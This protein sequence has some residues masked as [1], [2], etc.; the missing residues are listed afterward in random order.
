[1]GCDIHGMFEYMYKH[2][3]DD[4]DGR[5]TNAGDPYKWHR[6]Y[7]IY[8]ILGNVRNGHKIP[9]I[10][11]NRLIEYADYSQDDW[12]NMGY[13]D[14]CKAPCEEFQHLSANWKGDGHSHSFVTLAEMKAYDINQ[15][16]YDNR[17]ICGKDDDGNITSTCA[18]TT[19]EHFGPVGEI[20]IF[21]VWGSASWQ[22]LI[23]Y[24]EMIREFYGLKDD[25]VRYTFFFDN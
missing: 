12:K 23:D 1:M 24:G 8:A 13:L 16:Y 20:T 3:K 7:T 18:S 17:L 2:S 5:W 22:R 6:N 19:G 25:E 4:T 9:Y 21:G 14:Y 10:A 15:K 11:E